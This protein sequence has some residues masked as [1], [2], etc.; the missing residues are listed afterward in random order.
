MKQRYLV[1]LGEY[2]FYAL[3]AI[4]AI[5]AVIFYINAGNINSKDSYAKQL[6]DAGP[7]LNYLAYWLYLLIALAVFFAVLFP[8][9]RMFGNPK[10]AIKTFIGIVVVAILIFVAWQF[11]DG[12]IMDIAG[13]TGPDNIPTRLKM[14]DVAIFMMYALVGVAGLSLIYAEVSKLFK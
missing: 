4:S 9:I 14:V 13:Y 3:L 5:L 1:R 11:A 8:V 7:I 6:A 12:T 2:F 10:S